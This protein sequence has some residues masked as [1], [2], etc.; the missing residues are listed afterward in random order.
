LAW[1]K[2]IR[3]R[4]AKRSRI[5]IA[6]RKD[7]ALFNSFVAEWLD[8]IPPSNLLRLDVSSESSN[9]PKSVQAILERLTE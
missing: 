2:N 8:S 7:T 6:S 5:N 1:R 4:L 3:Q 9:Y